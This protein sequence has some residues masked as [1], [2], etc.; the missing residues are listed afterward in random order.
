MLRLTLVTGVVVAS[1]RPALAIVPTVLVSTAT[2][3]RWLEAHCNDDV[4]SDVRGCTNNVL[5]R[6]SSWTVLVG[7]DGA[8]PTAAG[9]GSTGSTQADK[10]G[11]KSASVVTIA[12]VGLIVVGAGV[13][14]V[15]E[16]GL[17]RVACSTVPSTEWTGADN[18]LPWSRGPRAGTWEEGD[19]QRRRRLLRNVRCSVTQPLTSASTTA[20]GGAGLT[21]VIGLLVTWDVD[22]APDVLY[23]DVFVDADFVGRSRQRRLFV[24][25]P[26]VKVADPDAVVVSVVPTTVDGACTREVV[27][28][29][30]L[31]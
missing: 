1:S 19:S 7:G 13:C 5:W 11:A 28:V 26:R 8:T 21:S 2:S 18:V 10:T 31:S 4:D 3:S 16:L 20:G 25:V 17:V 12:A 27:L 15:G 29:P 24:E 6:R 14:F 23:C 30:L 9:S 22:S